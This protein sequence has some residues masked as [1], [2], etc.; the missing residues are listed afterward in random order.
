MSCCG[1]KREALAASWSAPQQETNA[2]GSTDDVESNVPQDNARFRY[3]GSGSLDV[4]GV[5]SRRLYKFST[6]VRELVVT[7]EDVS[8]MRAYAELTELKN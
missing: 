6:G 1:K 3:T 4:D 2:N 5:F 8:V 7:P